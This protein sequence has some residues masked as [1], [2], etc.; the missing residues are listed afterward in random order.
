M[1]NLECRHSDPGPQI[2]WLRNKHGFDFRQ[3][4]LIGRGVDQ[5]LVRA[6]ANDPKLDAGDR[7]SRRHDHL[8][9]AGDLVDAWRLSM[10]IDRAQSFIA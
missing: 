7:V 5:L 8:Q 6:L 1:D 2:A 4:Q 9:P 3:A 10:R